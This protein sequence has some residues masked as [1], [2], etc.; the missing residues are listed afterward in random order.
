VE[1]GFLWF[2]RLCLRINTTSIQIRTK[3]AMPPITAPAMR[4]GDGVED[5]DVEA[6]T[7][8]ESDLELFVVVG[9]VVDETDVG[10]GRVLLALEIRA[11]VCDVVCAGGA[12]GRLGIAVGMAMLTLWLDKKDA[13]T[14]PT[15]CKMLFICLRC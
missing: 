1:R 13:T 4:P 12:M 9:L 5:L 3:T 11:L 7:D 6:A 14:P 15:L 8:G 2:L 10:V